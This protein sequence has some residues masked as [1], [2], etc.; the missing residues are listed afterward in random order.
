M[1]PEKQ[2]LASD[3]S[4]TDNDDEDIEIFVKVLDGDTFTVTLSNTATILG[5]KMLI[6]DQQYVNADRQ[7]L[8]YR[9][10]ELLDNLSLSQYGISNGCTVHLV[11]LQNA[12][13]NPIRRNGID[14]MSVVRLCQFIRMFAFIEAIF[15][16]IHG[17][18]TFHFVSALA[19]LA[20]AGYFGAKNLHR[21]CLILYCLCLILE[22][23]VHS[24]MIWMW[25]N[26]ENVISSALLFLMICIDLFAARCVYKLYRVIPI[27]GPDQR[28]TILTSNSFCTCLI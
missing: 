27:L 14:T 23:S 20:I 6:D 26:Y 19:L 16:I 10:Q 22:I 5:L 2:H 11:V 4:D 18:Q 8:I 1:D 28:Q 7:H 21:K 17:I 3:S 12:Q 9:S 24:Y 15:L 13:Q 25:M